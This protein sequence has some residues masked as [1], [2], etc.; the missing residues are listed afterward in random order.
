[1]S[2]SVFRYLSFSSV[3]CLRLVFAGLCQLLQRFPESQGSFGT[4]SFLFVFA[5]IV[6]TRIGVYTAF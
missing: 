6:V 4:P 5:P 1:M 2:L 3:N